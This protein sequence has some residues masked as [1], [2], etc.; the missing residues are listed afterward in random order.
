[1]YREQDAKTIAKMEPLLTKKFAELADVAERTVPP[2]G[3]FKP[4]FALFEDE[5]KSMDIASWSLVI[6]DLIYNN[7]GT[8]VLSTRY[9]ELRGYPGGCYCI[10]RIVGFGSV[11]ECAELLRS[12]TFVAKVMDA[13]KE[14]LHKS[15]DI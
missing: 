13:M 8:D 6:Y 12:H 14:L 10:T 9:L 2:S 11:E 5:T 7:C 3:K 4:Q 15:D 1:M